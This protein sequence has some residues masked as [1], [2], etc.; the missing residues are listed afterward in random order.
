MQKN[1]IASP[2]RKVEVIIP[3]RRPHLFKLPPP[4]PA[5]EFQVRV[6]IKKAS[7]NLVPNISPDK[8]EA[9]CKLFGIAQ[10]LV[11][12]AVSELSKQGV[13]SSHVMDGKGV[14]KR[15]LESKCVTANAYGNQCK[16]KL[17]F[18][19]TPAAPPNISH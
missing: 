14:D 17:N 4:K 5:K 13:L 11:L 19:V 8:D 15:T 1:S 6:R 3:D 9:I 2:A 16:P 7:P 10:G 12:K 18:Y